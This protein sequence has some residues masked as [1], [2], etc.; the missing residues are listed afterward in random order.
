MQKL[1]DFA[2]LCPLQHFA[3]NGMSF[4]HLPLKAQESILKMGLKNFYEPELMYNFK[5][6][7][8][9]RNNINTYMKSQILCGVCKSCT[10]SSETKIPIFRKCSR[11]N[12]P[13]VTREECVCLCVLGFKFY[14]LIY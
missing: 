3:L 1:S 9:S 14:S 8:F 6:K 7:V 10:T 11:S 5:E 13:P 12:V 4:L 2:A